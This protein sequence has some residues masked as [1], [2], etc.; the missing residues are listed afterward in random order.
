MEK[1]NLINLQQFFEIDYK[2][3]KLMYNNVPPHE[4]GYLDNESLCKYTKELEESLIYIF[5][6]LKSITLNIFGEKSPFYIKIENLEIEIK[7]K[8]YSC[9]LDINKLRKFYERYISNM[10]ENFIDEVKE[11]CVGYT[12]R[13]SIPTYRV[14]SIN[15]MLHLLHMYVLNNEVILQAIPVIEEKQNDYNY[16]IRFRGYNTEITK[17]IFQQFPDNLD[18]GWTDIV[19]LDENKLL[20]MVRD[21]GH[22]LTIEITIIDNKARIEYFIPKLCNIDMINNLPG[23]NKVTQNDFGA[24]GVIETDINHLQNILYDFISKV[25]MDSDMIL[26]NIR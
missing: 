21:R 1:N 4:K 12:L 9:G 5:Y 23:V 19:S 16:P 3:K 8:F 6:K 25:P 11:K 13:D 20:M 22:A 7:E 15:E 26:P 2:I 14:N 24:T 10:E 17:Q 18:V